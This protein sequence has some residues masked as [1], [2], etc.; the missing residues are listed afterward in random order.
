VNDFVHGRVIVS[1]VLCC[2]KVMEMTSIV[3]CK[4]SCKNITCL[5]CHWPMSVWSPCRTLDH[6]TKEWM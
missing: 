2:S 6:R 5:L 1:V 4:S 3:A